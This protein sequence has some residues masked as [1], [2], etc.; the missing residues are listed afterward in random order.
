M[1]AISLRMSKNLKLE[2]LCRN[3]VYELE[4]NSALLSIEGEVD[5]SLTYKLHISHA[6]SK[7]YLVMDK[8]EDGISKLIT[9]PYIAENG[10]YYI[11]LEAIK[12]DFRL[13]S[14]QIRLEVGSF[15]NAENIPTP[16]EQSIIDNLL[17]KVTALDN[18]VD[19][20]DA[21]VSVLGD[22]V[23]DVEED[24]STLND[25]IA[26]KQDTLVAGENITIEGNV[27]SAQGGT[28]DVTKEYVD[29]GLATKQDK[30]D[31]ALKSDIPV[32]DVTKAYVDAGLDTKQSKGDYALKSDIPTVPKNVSAFTNDAG[33]VKS[34]ELPT[35]P[36]KT[37]QLTNDSGFVTG[38]VVRTV[39]NT[40]PDANGNVNVS[41]GGGASIDDSKI[42]TDSTWSSSKI[43]SELGTVK[44]D[45]S[46]LDNEL[47]SVDGR[48]TTLENTPIPEQT[49][50]NAVNSYVEQH[51]GGFATEEQLNNFQPYYLKHS[52]SNVLLENK[53]IEVTTPTAQSWKGNFKFNVDCKFDDKLYF[54]CSDWKVSKDTG[55][56]IVTEY[57]KDGHALGVGAYQ[58][59]GFNTDDYFRVSKDDTAYCEISIWLVVSTSIA[60]TTYYVNDLLILKNDNGIVTYGFD[61][62][63][64]VSLSQIN[65]QL[66]PNIYSIN[67][68]G[69]NLT[70]PE[71]TIPAFAESK[72]KG[73]DFI[74]CD[75]MFSADGVPVVIHDYTIDRTSNGTG[76]VED[77]T[78]E[79]LKS[80]DFGSWKSEKYTGTKI[81]TLEETVSFCRLAGLGIYLEIKLDSAMTQARINTIVNIVKKYNMNKSVSYIAYYTSY[82]SWVLEA[83]PTSRVGLLSNEVTLEEVNSIGAIKTADNK[84][85]I[86]ASAIS[87]SLIDEC[88]SRN[89]PVEKWVVNNVDTMLN[90][91]PYINGFTSDYVNAGAELQR[92]ALKV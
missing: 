72:V 52:Y 53:R 68:R 86:D 88:I 60:G 15:I 7:T 87:D 14:N 37:S 4:N 62:G 64:V 73:F 34:S 5:E 50:A 55:F 29:T 81:P 17:I 66:S 45:L 61:N 10:V 38:A 48:V 69:Y 77:L 24:I 3:N 13:I 83:E 18:A 90:A 33:Y 23:D 12:E 76:R 47:S 44:S 59:Y 57:D 26:G 51:S 27:I 70:A 1:K 78:L 40:V 30:G 22:R 49:V 80:Y 6:G 35:V 58:Q 84:I 19:G 71:N 39:N 20:I 36:T 43:N 67:H 89:I 25:K 54:R 92:I 2:L 41:S 21:A 91:N 28:G 11:Q 56:I 79:Q 75:V 65:K 9:A 74:E 63:F 42:A 85:F 16:E 32:V 31:Y 8:N 82:L 46:E